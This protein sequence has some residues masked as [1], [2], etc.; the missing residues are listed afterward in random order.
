MG[1]RLLE[2][3]ILE[4]GG[5]VEERKRKLKLKPLI[6]LLKLKSMMKEEHQKLKLEK[7]EWLRLEIS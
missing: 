7:E 4:I 6:Q 5:Q 2:H 1:R 3:V